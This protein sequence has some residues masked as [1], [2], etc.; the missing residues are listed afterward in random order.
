MESVARSGAFLHYVMMFHPT[1]SWLI[2]WGEQDLPKKQYLSILI[3]NS[4]SKN[5]LATRTPCESL[6]YSICSLG[7]SHIFLWGLGMSKCAPAQ[8]YIVAG[9]SNRWL[10]HQSSVNL[11]ASARSTRNAACQHAAS[12]HSGF[13]IQRIMWMHFSEKK[14]RIGDVETYPGLKTERM[15]FFRFPNRLLQ[16]VLLNSCLNYLCLR[17]CRRP[18]RS[19]AGPG[20]PILG[21]S[22]YSKSLFLLALCRWYIFHTKSLDKIISRI[23]H[24]W[25]SDVS[26]WIPALTLC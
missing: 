21:G 25:M 4:E 10:T 11:P 18:E 7:G 3:Y 15:H 24:Q 2:V 23:L 1:S 17:N 8:I 26:R 16:L 19:P 22:A 9:S 13:A 5:A 14:K 12:S 20:A 6:W